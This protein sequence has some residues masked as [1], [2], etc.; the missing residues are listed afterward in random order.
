MLTKLTTR[1][2]FSGLPGKPQK[3]TTKGKHQ[4]PQSNIDERLN[5]VGQPGET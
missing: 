4:Q 2:G 5:L 3:G 1:Q